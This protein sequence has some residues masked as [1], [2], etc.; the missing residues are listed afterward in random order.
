MMRSAEFR[1]QAFCFFIET[2]LYD[3]CGRRGGLSLANVRA[4]SLLSIAVAAGGGKAMT[5]PEW[6]FFGTAE[7]DSG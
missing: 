7:L 1:P 2:P 3:A 4:V 6:A 5:A